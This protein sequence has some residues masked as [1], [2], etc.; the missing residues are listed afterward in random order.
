M[1]NYNIRKKWEAYTVI[2]PSNKVVA[3]VYGSDPKTNDGKVIVKT[4]LD[5]SGESH[6]CKIKK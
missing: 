2:K 3:G 4:I 1:V 5:I 6:D